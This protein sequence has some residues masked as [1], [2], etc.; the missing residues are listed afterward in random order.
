M[1]RAESGH[2]FL[3]GEKDI[4]RCKEHTMHCGHTSVITP[5][6]SAALKLL[7]KN[8]MLAKMFTVSE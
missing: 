5:C 1:K 6:F 2:K 7:P 4:T 3:F 8:I